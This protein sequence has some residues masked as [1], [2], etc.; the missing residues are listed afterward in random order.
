M[1][2]RVRSGMSV[3]TEMLCDGKTRPI[4]VDA[5]LEVFTKMFPQSAPSLTDVN[6]RAAMAGDAVNQNGGQTSRGVFDG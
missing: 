4:L 6:G 1:D 5:S 3:R 2:R